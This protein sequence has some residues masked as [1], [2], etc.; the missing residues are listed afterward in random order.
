MCNVYYYMRVYVLHS[1]ASNLI[2]ADTSGFSPGK[3]IE[4]RQV[5]VDW[6][7]LSTTSIILATTSMT[8]IED[9][10]WRAVIA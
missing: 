3:K 10:S 6:A 7:E 4:V 2:I 8:A 5:G 9:A 1:I